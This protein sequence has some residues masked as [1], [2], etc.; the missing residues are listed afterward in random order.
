MIYEMAY[1]GRKEQN[2]RDITSVITN[3]EHTMFSLV[4]PILQILVFRST[5]SR[6]TVV[7]L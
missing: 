1:G 6:V 4:W 2:Q 3:Q 7:I 5:L